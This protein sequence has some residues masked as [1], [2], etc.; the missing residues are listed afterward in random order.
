[1]LGRRWAARSTVTENAA[2]WRP[3][4]V[5][6]WQQHQNQT[7]TETVVSEL[8][9]LLV[10]LVVVPSSVLGSAP[11][12]VGVGAGVARWQSSMHVIAML[13]VSASVRAV[14]TRPGQV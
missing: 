9:V 12:D 7:Q 10:V 13:F 6:A 2:K 3:R 5:R 4:A 11:G 8:E 14:E 1:M